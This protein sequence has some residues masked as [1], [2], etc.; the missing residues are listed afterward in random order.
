MKFSENESICPIT[1]FFVNYIII[2]NCRL[3][4]KNLSFIVP[5][6]YFAKTISSV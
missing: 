3:V 2:M 6:K 4:V 5:G 1:C